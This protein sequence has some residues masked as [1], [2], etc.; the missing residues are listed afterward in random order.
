MI[1]TL[2]PQ[3]GENLFDG[4]SLWTLKN[5]GEISEHTVKNEDT[6]KIHQV[7]I[8]FTREVPPGDYQWLQLMVIFENIL[9]IFFRDLVNNFFLKKIFT[10]YSC[11][12]DFSNFGFTNG[13]SV[14]NE[15]KPGRMIFH[16]LVKSKE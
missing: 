16:L 8:K 6:N 14:S 4:G 10:E 7:R 11:Q 5:L 9:K 2:N 1:R 12:K 13:R 15:E 3:I